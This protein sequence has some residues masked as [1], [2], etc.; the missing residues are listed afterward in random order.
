M[1]YEGK[2]GS[3]WI[4]ASNKSVYQIKIPRYEKLRYTLG[5]KYAEIDTEMCSA[6]MPY[7]KMETCREYIFNVGP[8]VL[9]C[10]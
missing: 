7:T 1:I 10:N 8:N 6:H 3:V 2:N 4:S 5:G 9:K